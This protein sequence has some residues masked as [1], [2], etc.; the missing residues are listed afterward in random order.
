MERPVLG[1]RYELG[2]AIGSGGFGTVFRARDRRTETDVA[3]KLVLPGLGSAAA[4]Q[5]LRR[6]AQLLRRVVSRHVARVYDSGDD[7]AGVWLVTELVEGASLSPA[8]LGRALLPHEVLRVARGLLEG[9]AAVHA[10][11]IVHGDVKPS[12]VLVPGGSK[13]LD[14]AKIVDFG[15]AR[16][17]SRADVAA[18]IGEEDVREGMVLGTARYM[19]PELLSGGDASMRADLYAA[20]LLLFELLDIGPLFPVTSGPSQW[21][22]RAFEEPVLRPRVPPPLSDVLGRMLACDPAARYPDAAAA[23]VA[24][25]DLDTAP[26]A[27]LRERD[28]AVARARLSLLAPVQGPAT[29]EPMSR[30]STAAPARSIVTASIRPP[31]DALRSAPPRPFS[32]LSLLPADSVVALRETLRQLDL[33]MLDALARRE[34]GNPMGRISRAVALALRLELD[35]AALILEP[36]GASSDVARSVG[37]AL[38]APRARRVTR[39][40]VGIDEAD[41][42]LDTI[43]AELA[44]ILVVFAECLGT[45]DD[46]GRGSRRCARALA[47]LDAIDVSGALAP[48]AAATRASLRIVE[49]AA[50]IQSAEIERSAAAALLVTLSN[51]A[52]KNDAPLLAVARALATATLSTGA[53]R[54]SEA[55]ARTERALSGLG[56]PLLDAALASALGALAISVGPA[57]ERALR[58]LERATTLLANGDAPSLEH[59][60][61]HHL[62]MALVARGRWADAIEHF[63]AAREV[64]HGEQ[65]SDLGLLSVSIEVLAALATGDLHAAYEAAALLEESRLA[66]AARKTAAFA[67]VARSLTSLS[68][69]DRVAA[70]EALAEAKKVVGPDDKEARVIVELL[71]ILFEAAREDVGDLGYAMAELGRL[72]E[73]VGF[74]TSFW[75]DLIG[76]VMSRMPDPEAWN[77][78]RGMLVRLGPLVGSHSRFARENPTE[79]TTTALS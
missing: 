74:D 43:D 7:E 21:K 4:A 39:A 50:R 22:T 79:S 33:P 13:T 34:R 14:G 66:K 20:G 64:A 67:W 10:A 35:A 48:S 57:D 17:V 11:G 62:G 5:R 72:A 19:A 47:R 27:L 73:H 68:G 25:A 71:E 45:N 63:H 18:S 16:F 15:L 60:A 42:W 59:E 31:L 1:G 6:E 37:A 52:E 58:L 12:N 2:P 41:R 75:F 77:R 76:A 44:A 65:A 69:S 56:V 24:V 40:R 38:V 29:L 3:V 51:V 23:H 36:L 26:V 30:A 54:S 32:R 8:T 78:M 9:L 61:Q 70:L 46:V 53:V 49:L 55:L 28:S